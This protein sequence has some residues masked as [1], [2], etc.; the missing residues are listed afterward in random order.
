MDGYILPSPVFVCVCLSLSYYLLLVGYVCVGGGG[1]GGV[2]FVLSLLAVGLLMFGCIFT[3][4]FPSFPHVVWS[5]AG[6]T[7]HFVAHP[8]QKRIINAN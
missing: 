5:T 7:I 1:G 8:R 4:R 6:R 2:P 3:T